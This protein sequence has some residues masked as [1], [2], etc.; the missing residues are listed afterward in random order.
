MTLSLAVTLV[1]ALWASHGGTLDLAEVDEIDFDNPCGLLS[2][3][4]ED[5]RVSRHVA[6]YAR[7]G[8]RLHAQLAMTIDREPAA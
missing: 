2:T 1:T 3:E 8:G 5:G 7:C 4:H 6:W